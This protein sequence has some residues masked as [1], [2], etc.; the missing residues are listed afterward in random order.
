VGPRFKAPKFDAPARYRD[1]VGSSEAESI[2]DLPWWQV[3]KDPKLVALIDE[4]LRNNYDLQIAV[5][6]IEQSKALVGV[7]EAPLFPQLSYEGAAQREK[8]FEPPFPVNPTLNVFTGLFNMAWEI[9][10]W[11]RIR[12]ATEA[13]RANM[14]AAEYARRAVMLT[15]VS[16]VAAAY[17]QLLELD[18]EL[19]IARDSSDTYS[20]TLAYFTRRYEGGTDTRLSTSRA[21]ANL[22][23]SQASI[24]SLV[25]QIAQQ[26]NAISLLLGHI[27]RSI[28]RGDLPAGPMVHTVDGQTTVLLRRRPD[29][30]ESEQ[31]M[32]NANAEIGVALANFFPTIGVS[33]L[34]GGQSARIGDIVKSNF[35]VW[36]IGANISGPLFQGGR[37]YESYLAQQAYWDETVAQY[38]ATIIEAFREVSDALIAQQRLIKKRAALEKQVAALGVAVKL[39]LDRYR[40]GLAN[41]Y[42]VLEAEQLLYPAEDALAQTQ[43]DQL[44]AVVDLYKALGGGWNL[45]DQRWTPSR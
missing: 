20:E 41:Y 36:N 31:V 37:L 9:D 32:I 40:I 4:A 18:R 26:E 19:K 5:A 10:V 29:I 34:Y 25:I 42:E 7:A 28:E 2:A 11:G 45:S 30:L 39:S 3:F 13:A 33:A 38:D 6:R 35:A 22:A 15:L 17:F 12:R 27:P 23:A 1:Q 14:L 43:R 21:E 16:N 8:I 44:L 24:E